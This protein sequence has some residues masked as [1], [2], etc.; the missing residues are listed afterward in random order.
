MR[1]SWTVFRTVFRGGP[2]VTAGPRENLRG[3]DS[4]GAQ[5]PHSGAA[6]DPSHGNPHHNVYSHGHD[7]PNPWFN[8]SPYGLDPP[9]VGDVGGMGG[10]ID[11]GSMFSQAN[12]SRAPGG[13]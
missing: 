7:P 2:T 5:P 10:G 1:R 9:E 11:F 13:H 3:S 4:N 6:P 8:M 12:A